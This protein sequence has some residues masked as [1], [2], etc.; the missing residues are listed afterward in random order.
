MCRLSLRLYGAVWRL[1]F[2][3]GTR[4]LVA[5]VTFLKALF[6]LRDMTRQSE[7]VSQAFLALYTIAQH[8]SESVCLP[9]HLPTYLHISVFLSVHLPAS[10]PACLSAYIYISTECKVQSIQRE[11]KKANVHH[12][13]GE[14]TVPLKLWHSVGPVWKTNSV[15]LTSDVLHSE[16]ADGNR[17]NRS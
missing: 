16:P 9:T 4:R 10:L 2:W 3:D 12:D 7:T 5:S 1:R 13:R 11:E 17:K 15:P 8:T 14:E 6:F